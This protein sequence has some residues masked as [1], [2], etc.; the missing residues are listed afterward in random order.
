MIRLEKREINTIY[1][2]LSLIEATYV[3]DAIEAEIKSG[4]IS[5][6]RK[7]LLKE[8]LE[9]INEEFRTVTMIL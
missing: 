7:D 1:L 5:K 9:Q 2:K 8:V 6:E 4:S 3:L